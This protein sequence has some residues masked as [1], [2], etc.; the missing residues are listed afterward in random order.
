VPRVGVTGT[1]VF[2]AKEGLPAVGRIRGSAAPHLQEHSPI[3]LSKSDPAEILKRSYRQTLQLSSPFRKTSVKSE[4]IRVVSCHGVGSN[5]PYLVL[6][7]LIA[8]HWGGL[9]GSTSKVAVNALSSNQ[10]PMRERWGFENAC[11][12][13]RHLWHVSLLCRSHTSTGPFA[14]YLSDS[15]MGEVW[16]TCEMH[17]NRGSKLMTPA[18]VPFRRPD[19]DG[20][21]QQPDSVTVLLICLFEGSP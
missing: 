6:H 9:G 7:C 17:I 20:E 12:C 11:L 10:F 18:T 19:Y 2:L 14:A 5:N 1:R 21:V 16:E 3:A 8:N 4:Q 15:L 13:P